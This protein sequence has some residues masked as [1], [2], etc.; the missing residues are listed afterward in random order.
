MLMRLANLH[1]SIIGGLFSAISFYPP[2]QAGGSLSLKSQERK[3]ENAPA[4]NSL[5]FLFSLSFCFFFVFVFVFFTILYYVVLRC[6]FLYIYPAFGFS[7]IPGS[8]NCF[9]SA[10]EVELTFILYCLI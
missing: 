1:Y 7:K 8:V 2:G 5:S 9:K 4:R 6:N 3:R 10:S